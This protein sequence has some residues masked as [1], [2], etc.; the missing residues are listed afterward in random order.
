LQ[1]SDEEKELLIFKQTGTGHPM[2]KE[3]EGVESYRKV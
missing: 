1:S 3:S 2:P